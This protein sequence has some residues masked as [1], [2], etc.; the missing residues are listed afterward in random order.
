[1]YRLKK[2]LD[3]NR[4]WVSTRWTKDGI[5]LGSNNPELNLKLPLLQ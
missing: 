4:S 5:Y 1:M 2:P 3:P